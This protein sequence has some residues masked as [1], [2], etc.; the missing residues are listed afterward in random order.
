M[1]APGRHRLTHRRFTAAAVALTASGGA[2]AYTAT[3]PAPVFTVSSRAQPAE[4]LNS[5]SRTEPR[6]ILLT[7]DGTGASAG[8]GNLVNGRGA[9]PVATYDAENPG[10]RSRPTANRR[11]ALPAGR[12]VPA[13]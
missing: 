8:T 4:A 6:I 3:A 5:G 7:G 1:T 11:P 9:D 10:R 12:A 13:P 2:V